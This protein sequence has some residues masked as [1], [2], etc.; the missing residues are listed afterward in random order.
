MLS[1]SEGVL[2][3]EFAL[4]QKPGARTIS[5][6]PN[7]SPEKK[8]LILDLVAVLK[9]L[10]L[11]VLLNFVIS[12]IVKINATD[13]EILALPVAIPS[14][15]SPSIYFLSDMAFDIPSTKKHTGHK[16]TKLAREKRYDPIKPGVKIPSNPSKVPISK[17]YKAHFSLTADC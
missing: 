4:T 3:I 7:N 14:K 16:C 17:M 9:P 12:K 11:L 10:I 5:N 1:D 15:K 2:C 13:S 8:I 6:V